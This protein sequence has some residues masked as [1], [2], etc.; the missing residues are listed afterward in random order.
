MRLSKF[1][2]GPAL[3]V[4]LLVGSA[5]IGAA[6]AQARGHGLPAHAP[7][8][9]MLGGG[10]GI[11]IEYGCGW[12]D[13]GGGGTP[14]NAW[15]YD[16]S[17]FTDTKDKSP[18]QVLN[19]PRL[20]PSSDS[21]YSCV[22]GANGSAL[23]TRY[24]DSPP[25]TGVSNAT[26]S[27]LANGTIANTGS[28]LGF[29]ENDNVTCP[30]GRGCFLINVYYKNYRAD[31]MY[32]YDSP[33]STPYILSVGWNKNDGKGYAGKGSYIG[34]SSGFLTAATDAG[35]LDDPAQIDVGSSMMT[36]T[37]TTTGGDAQY[38]LN[39]SAQTAGS[40]LVHLST[41]GLQATSNRVIPA[42]WIAEPSA[43]PAV[44]VYLIPNLDA[45]KSATATLYYTVTGAS[46]DTVFADVN[47][48]S[49]A[50][51]LTVRPSAPTCTTANS[52]FNGRSLVPQGGAVTVL[53]G[54]YCTSQPDSTLKVWTGDQRG[55][56]QLAVIGSGN[57]HAISYQ[58]PNASYVGDDTVYVYSENSAGVAS[59]PTAVPVTVAAPA[60]AVADSY[61]V[62]KNAP[63]AVDV[64]H[65]LLANDQFTTGTDGW[66]VQQGYAPLNGD[67][68]MNANG[69]F[70]Y[71][72]H[73]GYSGDDTFRYRLNGPHNAVSQPVTVTIHV[74]N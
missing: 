65:G 46:S 49:T 11:S 74:T 15:G 73:P 69:S 51:T 19:D 64:A 50:A 62:A 13:V 32:E 72:P 33:G 14:G 4:L 27:Q 39:I 20:F 45:N 5:T 58:A 17:M 23:C 60:S 34:Q 16:R 55:D 59:L 66:T 53:D 10:S 52:S 7:V 21:G 44:L 54:A 18:W 29:E 31:A 67:L 28:V 43:D 57:T 6:S 35:D 2:W 61:T 26:V 41:I 24:S 70:S 30:N 22:P 63:L 37:A 3:T 12:G 8:V 47:G 68:T 71:T 38:Q 56:G 9:C 36:S 42:G 25:K 1:V 48:S 40:V